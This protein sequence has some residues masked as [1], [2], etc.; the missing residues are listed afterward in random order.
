MTRIIKVQREPIE[1]DAIVGELSRPDCGAVLSFLGLVR[2]H[3]GGRE[4]ESIDYSCYEEMAAKELDRVV[5]RCQE[6][7][8]VAHAAV[9]HRI[10]LLAVGEASLGLVVASPHRRE[11][12]A[13]GLDIIDEMKKT[14]PIWKREFGPDGASWV[15]PGQPGT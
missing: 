10:G 14:V 3:A 1:L 8:G 11:A 6:R 15:D 13:C 9:V 4:V 7:H 2:D 5:A 12:F